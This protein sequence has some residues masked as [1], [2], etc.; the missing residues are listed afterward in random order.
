MKAADLKKLLEPIPDDQDILIW[1][2]FVSDW[3]DIGKIQES[4]L[5]R[6]TFENY[7]RYWMLETGLKADAEM[8][9]EDLEICKEQY[10]RYVK[11]W[12][13]EEFVTTEDVA[14]GK[15]EE[16]KIILIEPQARGISTFDRNGNI[17]Y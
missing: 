11:H 16:K 7:K 12:T 15:Y 3:Q 17:E 8:S 13:F 10:A 5:H 2:G 6:Q 4:S 9:S 14:E 1:N